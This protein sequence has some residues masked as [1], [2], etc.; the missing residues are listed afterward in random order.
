[1]EFLW[2]LFSKSRSEPTLEAVDP[3]PTL[4]SSPADAL[5]LLE[6]GPPFNTLD[7]DVDFG[8]SGASTG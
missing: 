1:M 4:S 3:E 6:P 5:L 2:N 8:V 7:P